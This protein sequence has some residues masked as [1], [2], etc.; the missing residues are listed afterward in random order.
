MIDN[1]SDHLP[2]TLEINYSFNKNTALFSENLSETSFEN[3][4]RWSKFLFEEITE[5]YVVL[6]SNDLELMSLEDNNSLANS[7][8]KMK[9]L[10]LNHSVSLI[11]PLNSEK[12]SKKV[13][14]KPP[15]DVKLA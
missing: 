5:S 7:A 8:E 1:T 2:N 9:N 6:I 4:I 14:F 13:F 12:N 3:I 15:D 11:R 10:I